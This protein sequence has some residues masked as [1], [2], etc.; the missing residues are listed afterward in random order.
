MELSICPRILKR[1]MVIN[2]ALNFPG[3]M[4][5]TDRIIVD[6]CIQKMLPEG[7]DEE[8]ANEKKNCCLD[9]LEL[10]IFVSSRM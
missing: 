2:G 10:D 7:K 6:V 5:Y 8:S 4:V 9:D 1:K 3:N